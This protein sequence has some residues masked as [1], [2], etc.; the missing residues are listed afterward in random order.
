MPRIE[1]DFDHDRQAFSKMDSFSRE[2]FLRPFAAKIAGIAVP[3]QMKGVSY[4][5]FPA[6][7]TSSVLRLAELLGEEAAA[8]PS[9]ENVREMPEIES[10]I[11]QQGYALFISGQ[12]YVVMAKPEPGNL[13]ETILERVRAIKA[14]STEV[15]SAED[16]PMQQIE[17]FSR[18]LT[19]ARLTKLMIKGK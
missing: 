6:E 8:K 17:A 12:H 19:N 11:A 2:L 3:K 16:A 9:K 1:L 7:E 13:M 15:E 4:L 18:K 5:L 10:I 14:P